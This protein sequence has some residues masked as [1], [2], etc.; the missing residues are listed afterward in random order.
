MSDQDVYK[1]EFQGDASISTTITVTPSQ[2]QQGDHIWFPVTCYLMEPDQQAVLD[3]QEVYHEGRCEVE[4]NLSPGT[5]YQ[6]V[7]F[8]RDVFENWT[9]GY[10][11]QITE[12]D[13]FGF[14]NSPRKRANNAETTHPRGA[15]VGEDI[16]LIEPLVRWDKLS[17]SPKV[18]IAEIGAQDSRSPGGTTLLNSSCR[19][20]PA[21][22]L[23]VF[24]A[25]VHHP[26]SSVHVTAC[27]LP[28]ELNQPWRE[29]RWTSRSTQRL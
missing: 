18:K 27:G 29:A 4:V 24:N 3:F 11:V 26:L 13:R 2:A 8:R 1:F 25:E 7:V 20:L 16:K 23:R 9:F 21:N 10:Q 15:P 22:F 17:P 28:V 5:E 19:S 12:H 14:E 6:F